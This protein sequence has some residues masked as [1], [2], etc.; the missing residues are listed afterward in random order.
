MSPNFYHKGDNKHQ[1]F[2]Y[3]FHKMSTI[4]QSEKTSRYANDFGSDLDESLGAQ[5]EEEKREH[6]H[7]QLFSPLKM[8]NEEEEGAK[9][10]VSDEVSI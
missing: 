10:S 8:I 9:L 7:N 1:G 6:P 3:S 4:F 2:N 5:Q